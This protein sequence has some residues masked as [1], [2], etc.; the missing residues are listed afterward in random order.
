M[1]NIQVMSIYTAISDCLS[2]T[3]YCRII[4]SIVSRMVLTVNIM[5]IDNHALEVSAGGETIAGIANGSGARC[6]G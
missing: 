3:S 6:S 4:N 5:M 2:V 1:G